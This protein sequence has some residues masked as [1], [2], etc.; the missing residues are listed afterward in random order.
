MPVIDKYTGVGNPLDHLEGY[1]SQM[2]LLNTQDDIKCKAF[3]TTLAGP[4]AVQ[5]NQNFSI[6]PLPVS[7]PIPESQF[8]HLTVVVA[9]TNIWKPAH[10]IAIA[11]IAITSTAIK[12]EEL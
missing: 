4:R 12:F 6:L 9:V 2:G 8:P 3:P 7:V 10:S 11:I 5:G 1:G